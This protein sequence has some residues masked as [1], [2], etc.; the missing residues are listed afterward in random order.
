M[1]ADLSRPTRAGLVGTGLLLCAAPV[2]AYFQLL[3]AATVDVPNL[4][5]YDTVVS[6]LNRFVDQ[7]SLAGRLRLVFAPHI[8]H[9]P[10]CNHA[11][12]PTPRYFR[13]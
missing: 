5:D 7:E 12:Q 6:F 1:N 4:D 3:L 13:E 10:A 2:V 11:R 8:E 9:R